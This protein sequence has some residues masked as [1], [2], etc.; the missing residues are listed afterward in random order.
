MI[1]EGHSDDNGRK[2]LLQ[3]TFTCVCVEVGWGGVLWDGGRGGGGSNQ[4]C[5]VISQLMRPLF[6]ARHTS[7]LCLPRQ[8]TPGEVIDIINS[9][10]AGKKPHLLA[11]LNF[12]NHKVLLS[13]FNFKAGFKSQLLRTSLGECC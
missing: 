4:S 5:A 8:S 6:A 3:I 9:A 7:P 12:T 10:A 2:S 11:L 1:D 13:H